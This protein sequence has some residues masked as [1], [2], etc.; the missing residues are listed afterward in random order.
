MIGEGSAADVARELAARIDLL[1]LELLPGGHREGHWWRAGDLDGSPGRSLLVNLS[2]PR[3]G[4]WKNFAGDEGGDS[5]DLVA[6]SRCGGDLRAALAWG[7]SWL[8][9]KPS[10]PISGSSDRRPADLRPPTLE[11]TQRAVATIWNVA[12]PLQRGD[13]VTRYFAGR[14]IDLA[15]LAAANYGRLPGVLCCHPNLRNEESG[16][17]WPAVV[18]AIANP[19]GELAAVHR[20]WLA[21]GSRENPDTGKMV[22]APLAAP[23][24]S[25]GSYTPGG[26]IRLWRGSSGRP[27]DAAGGDETLAIAEGIEDALTVAQAWP[28]RRVGCGVS[29]SAMLTIAVPAAIG[30]LVLVADNDPPFAPSTTLLRRVRQRF[31]DE[32][33]EV[34]LLRP[35]PAIKDINQLIQLGYGI[36]TASLGLDNGE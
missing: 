32:G 9:R 33:R 12:R 8:G 25:R 28:Y 13:A 29:L 10:S 20:I 2:G 17:C 11:E 15:A 36:G 6:Q 30:R 27:W 18:A 23:K 19:A 35:P 16:R 26:I 34:W 24:R 3:R 14:A 21:P 7:R 31:R 22:K 1:V 5:L 4:R